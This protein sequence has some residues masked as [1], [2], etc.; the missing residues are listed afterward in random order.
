MLLHSLLYIY[1]E[2]TGFQHADSTLLLSMCV[3][4]AQLMEHTQEACMMVYVYIRVVY[5]TQ[6]SLCAG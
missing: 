5:S 2:Y 4:V 1:I 6:L 3:S